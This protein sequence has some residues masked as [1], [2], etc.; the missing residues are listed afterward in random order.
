MIKALYAL[1]SECLN[2][3]F[4]EV[5][6]NNSTNELN[7]VDI[8][9]AISKPEDQLDSCSMLEETAEIV[10]CHDFPEGCKTFQP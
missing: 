8:L 5:L 6:R 9:F 10:E 1:G 3:E 2:R 4:G 7:A